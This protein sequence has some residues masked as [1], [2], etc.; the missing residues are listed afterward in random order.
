MRP[1]YT[2]TKRSRTTPARSVPAFML[3]E[4]PTCKVIG[5]VNDVY[6]RKCRWHCVVCVGLC[7][8]SSLRNY[9]VTRMHLQFLGHHVAAVV[10]LLLLCPPLC[11][12]THLLHQP[13]LRVSAISDLPLNMKYQRSF[14]TSVSYTHLTLPTKRIV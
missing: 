10:Y 5:L 8:G 12:L 7:L 14:S 2:T 11:L 3:I 13:H 1:T 6:S 9:N 4:Q